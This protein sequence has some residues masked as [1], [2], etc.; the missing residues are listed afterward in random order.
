MKKIEYWIHLTHPLNRFIP[1]PSSLRCSSLLIPFKK[2]TRLILSFQLFGF[3]PGLCARL[4][5]RL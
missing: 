1:H 5:A 2:R 4:R 3:N